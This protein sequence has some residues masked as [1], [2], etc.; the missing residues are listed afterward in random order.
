MPFPVLVQNYNTQQIFLGDNWDID[1]NCINASGSILTI[2][3][4]TVMGSLFTGNTCYPC[5]STATDGSEVPRFFARHDVVIA[6]G[7][8]AKVNLVYTGK[9]N[10]NAILFQ[11]GT[12]T[13]NTNIETQ[14]LGGSMQDCL[15]AYSQTV[16]VPSTELTITDPNQ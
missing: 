11:N 3:A 14:G 4:G 12:D 6:I 7:A 13:L 15:I 1:K 10:Q 2:L 9:V 5:V 8:T 16:L